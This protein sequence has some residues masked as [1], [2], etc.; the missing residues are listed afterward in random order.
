LNDLIQRF[1]L[2][3]FIF[4]IILLILQLPLSFIYSQSDEPIISESVGKPILPVGSYP[5]G[6]GINP[7]TNKLYVANQ[8]SNSVTV[9]DGN[10]NNIESTIQVD[11]FPYDLEVNSYNNR[12][13]VTN[14]GSNTVSVIDGSTNQRLSNI[15]VGESPVGISIDPSENIIYVTNLG[16][17]SS[18]SIIDGIS[19]KVTGTVELNGIF[20]GIAVNPLT[21]TIYL[22]NIK[23][24]TISVLDGTTKNVINHIPVEYIPTGLNINYKSD[25]IYVTNYGSNSISVINGKT[26]KVNSTIEV[27][28]NPVDTIINPLTNKIYVSN[29]GDNTVSVIDAVTNK[30]IKDLSVKPNSDKNNGNNDPILDIPINLTFPL[31][32]NKLALNPITNQIYITNTVSNGVI[33][34]DGK[35]DNVVVQL[36]VEIKPENA[37][38]ID[39]N[40]SKLPTQDFLLHP[41]NTEIK[42]TAHASR[43]YSF[44]F[45]SNMIA[46]TKNPITL[47]TTEN[48]L[49]VANFKPAISTEAYIGM[50]AATVGSTS[51]FAGWY[52]KRRERSYL[53]QSMNRIDFTYDA[54][55]KDKVEGVKQLEELRKEITNLFKKGKLTDSHY[56]ILDK[57][58][59]ELINILLRKD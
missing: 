35:T 1:S 27:G 30:K 34:V 33:I 19:N 45:W 36:S 49:L 11:N 51:I 14:R 23:N 2:A 37:G 38:T 20:Y 7:V 13:Y 22:S 50:I 31:L 46:D 52:Y 43:G 59:S 56:N 9:I 40:N 55:K 25:L 54:L 4:F 8:F 58:I 5:V 24:H 26:N 21:K 53:N 57:R 12:I 16:K 17:N 44:D 15:N 29:N 42:C 39:C 6:I 3:F 48:N 47:N 18:L 41:I 28:Q 32:A 10:T